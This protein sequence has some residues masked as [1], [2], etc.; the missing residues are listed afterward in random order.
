[1][2]RH[3]DV[4]VVLSGGGI[5]GVLFEVG[6]L[7]RLAESELWPRIGWFFGTSAGAVNGCMAA[8]DRIDELEEFVLGLKPEDTFRPN[9]LWRLPLLGSHDYTLPQT[10]AERI[11]DP[12]KIAV[13]LAAAEPEVVVV[14][15]DVT[16]GDDGDEDGPRLFER[17]Y[18]SKAD[19]P[20]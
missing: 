3:R 5:N 17:A 13:Q 12:V 16:A 10:I 4:A 8:L 20:E 14:V 1:M 19:P 11:A 6:F 7:K 15:T 9:R 18:S 2:E